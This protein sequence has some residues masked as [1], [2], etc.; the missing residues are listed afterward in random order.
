MDVLYV[1]Y[2]IEIVCVRCVVFMHVWFAFYA[3][4]MLREYLF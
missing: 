3:R 1:L 2:R 4:V